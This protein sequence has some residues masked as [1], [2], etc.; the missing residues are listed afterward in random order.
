[1][2]WA[3]TLRMQL[4]IGASLAMSS[5]GCGAFAEAFGGES[6]TDI[7]VFVTHHAS[8]NEH[9]EIPQRGE[10]EQQLF[11]TDEGWTIALDEAFI[12]TSAVTLHSCDGRSHD[13]EF[14]WGPV[15]E[16]LQAADFDLFSVGGTKV[17]AGRFCSMT[18]TYGPFDKTVGTAP[19]AA[20]TVHGTTVYLQGR[21]G[22][23][24]RVVEFEIR[25]DQ[26]ATVELDL[27][28]MEDGSPFR[29]HGDEPFPV[30]LTLSK[31]YDRFFDGVDFDAFS[32]DD[33]VQQVLAVLTL[34][35]RVSAD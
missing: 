22:K 13:L 6:K 26:L 30:E 2:G 18:V 19:R 5:A 20:D 16:D 33:M 27:S 31:T 9:G 8:P 28:G 24:D 21:A 17:E 14:Y 10:T 7:H 25:A 15:A 35:T 34:E 32:D 11:V 1:M 29:V 23:D 3:R 12:T 4:L